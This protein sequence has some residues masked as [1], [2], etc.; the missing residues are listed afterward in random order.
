MCLLCQ[1]VSVRSGLGPRYLRVSEKLV[2]VFLTRVGFISRDAEGVGGPYF[3][4]FSLSMSV[5]NV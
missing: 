1:R 4:G 2:S 3:A 5:G